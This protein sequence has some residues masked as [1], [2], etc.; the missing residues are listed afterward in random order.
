MESWVSPSADHAVSFHTGAMRGV[1]NADGAYHGVTDLCDLS[2]GREVI[3]PKYSA[4]NLFRLFAVHQGLGQ[5]RFDP[6]EVELHD[7]GLSIHWPET[8]DHLGELT[9]RYTVSSET[10]IDLA[11][12]AR[13]TG[14]YAGYELFLSNYFIPELVPHVY[15]EPTRYGSAERVAGEADVVVPLVN[16]VFR[17]TVIVF[18]R[19]THA[20]RRCVDG[21]WSR[22]ERGA[23]TVQMCPVRR[24]AFPVAV[25]ATPDGQRGLVLM[26]RPADCYAIST[27]YHADDEADRMTPYSAFDFSLFGH[28][29]QP[30]WECTVQMRLALT[31]LAGELQQP[32]ALYQA[33]VGTT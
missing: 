8:Q 15:L 32:R 28:D 30:G 12:T 9:A 14:T 6:R 27:R 26:S 11:V 7:D 22:S 29:T 10:S 4:L 19:D 23:P 20:A 18:P 3:H 1:L 13:T 21:R 25:V 16:D 24:H 17:G 2:T 5:P 31:S 33:W